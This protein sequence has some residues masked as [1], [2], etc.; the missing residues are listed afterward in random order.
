M[1]DETPPLIVGDALAAEMSEYPR[2]RWGRRKKK[3]TA[4]LTHCENCGAVLTG[5]YCAQCGQAAID[6]R[7]SF[8]ALMADAADAFFNL[9]RRIMTTF[10][11][12]LIKPW[13]LTNEFLAGR[14]HRYVHPLRLYLMAS[15]A[16]FFLVKGLEHFKPPS[17]QGT[18]VI[19]HGATA[20]STPASAAPNPTSS[21]SP[22]EDG[23]SFQL[24]PDDH[25]KSPFAAWL[26]GR[27]KEK[28][29]PLV[30]VASCF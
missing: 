5:P 14:R 9:D 1:S 26:Q 12:V 19:D 22:Q 11:L 4:P 23:F 24:P 7:R 8:G 30:I 15:V 2:R 27:I 29:G 18:I 28:I 16:F 3:K 21:A 25:P 13:R 10:A 20:H 6:Y 17:A